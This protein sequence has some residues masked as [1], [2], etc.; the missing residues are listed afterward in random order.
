MMKKELSGQS[1]RLLAA[2]LEAYSVE[3]LQQFKVHKPTVFCPC[4]ASLNEQ[5]PTPVID[6]LFNATYLSNFSRRE[7]LGIRVPPESFPWEMEQNFYYPKGFNRNDKRLIEEKKKIA[8][9]FNDLE[10]TPLIKIRKAFIHARESFPDIAK[11]YYYARIPQVILI[12]EKGNLKSYIAQY[13]NDEL[14]ENPTK[15]IRGFSELE[16]VIENQLS[17]IRRKP[18]LDKK[19]VYEHLKYFTSV[20]LCCSTST[21][22]SFSTA[23]SAITTRQQQRML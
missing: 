9:A 7:Q 11:L 14:K 15:Y 2:R 10:N 18:D 16:T 4:L 13:E 19:E 22:K 3:L 12:K 23:A 21:S 5:L 8:K 20:S 17:L 1:G 6:I